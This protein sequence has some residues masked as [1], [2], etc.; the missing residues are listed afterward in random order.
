MMK[1][2][3]V[4][5]VETKYSIGTI[6]K[7]TKMTA[8]TLHYYDEIG[9]LKA[10]RTAAGH[11]YYT[12]QDLITLQR[13]VSLKFLGYPLETIQQLLEKETWDTAE[14]FTF[15]REEMIKKRNQLNDSIRLLEHAQK[16]IE[17]QGELDPD[18]FFLLINSV[19]MEEEHKKWLKSFVPEQIVEDLYGISEEEQRE[20]EEQFISFVLRLKE[21]NLDDPEDDA[22]QQCIEDMMNFAK[23]VI[24]N[25]LI[26]YFSTMEDVQFDEADEWLFPT[27]LF[28]AE[29][30]KK[31]AAAMEVFFE[32][33]GGDFFGKRDEA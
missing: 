8:R 33:K 25:E 9:L 17:Q 27:F 18:L 32:N 20:L 21:M 26:N 13:I 11:R 15:Q 29:E 10:K 5:E 2:K 30:E 31:L 22:L 1:R 24:G 16:L 6:Q 3:E 12:K 23:S 19:Q 7:M 4:Q 28:T 14:Y